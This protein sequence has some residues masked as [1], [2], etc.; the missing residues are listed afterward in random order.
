[1]AEKRSLAEILADVSEFLFPAGVGEQLVTIHS[2]DADGDTALHVLAWQ[3]D[4]DGVHAL[5]EAGADVNA[6]GDMGYTPLHVAVAQGNTSLAAMLL[7]AGA[8]SDIISE[9]GGTAR[10]EA[11]QRG[12][13]LA[14]LFVQPDA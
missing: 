14:A 4:I 13:Q 3:N 12:G 5:I 8:R 6:A 1:M 7:Q 11:S 2:R 10:N 9:L